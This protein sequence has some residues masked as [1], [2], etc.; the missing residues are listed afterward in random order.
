MRRRRIDGVS[1]GS[2]SGANASA[3]AGASRWSA[4]TGP[5]SVLKVSVV[6]TGPPAGVTVAG[7]SAH[8][9]PVGSPEQANAT[10]PPNPPLGVIVKVVLAL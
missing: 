10:G 5:P 2:S 1:P 7:E 8:A 3:K 9:A 6:D 4:A